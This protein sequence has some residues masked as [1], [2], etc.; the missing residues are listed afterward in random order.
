MMIAMS[1]LAFPSEDIR[2][3]LALW[4][5]DGLAGIEVAP[6]RLAP[7]DGLT[8]EILGNYRRTLEDS[9]LVIP[10]LQALLFA[11]EGV[12]LLGDE[13]S[14]ERM[15]EH[16][17][18]VAG[19][20]CQL[21]AK[22]MVLGAPRQRSRGSLP[23]SQA[24]V[25]GEE[26]LRKCAEAVYKEAEI[27]LGLEPVPAAYGGDFLETAEEVTRMVRTVAH[28]GLRL[29]LDTGCVKL[30]GGDI[31]AAVHAGAPWLSH[32]HAAEPDLGAFTNPV[33][34]HLG[35]ALA[36]V[37]IEYSAWISI[38]MRQVDDWEAAVPAALRFVHG[39]YV[40][41]AGRAGGDFSTS[42]PPTSP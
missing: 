33:A 7:W 31:S 27:A 35:A 34:D 20:A 24:I 42:S 14:F 29:H 18:Y 4:K 16:L 9:G 10:S 39:K 30:G 23:M 38:E 32:F 5:A 25:L 15:V 37:E 40:A 11:K 36:L 8:P 28:P 22:I 41:S 12:A 17:R 1:N 2:R 26:R 3:S 21:G 19:I 13:E 6:T